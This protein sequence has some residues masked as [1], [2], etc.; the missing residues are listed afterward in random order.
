MVMLSDVHVEEEVVA[1]LI[2][3]EIVDIMMDIV[4]VEL[5]HVHVQLLAKIVELRTAIAVAVARQD[6]KAICVKLALTQMLHVA[7]MEDL[8]TQNYVDVRVQISV[9]MVE[10][11]IMIVHVHVR[12]D[13]LE[14]NVKFVDGTILHVLI[15]ECFYQTHVHVV[16]TRTHNV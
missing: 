6:G 9:K 1:I 14:I 11:W 16:V 3:W 15:M 12:M 2:L 5:V 8:L 7:I 13:G 4:Q 10:H